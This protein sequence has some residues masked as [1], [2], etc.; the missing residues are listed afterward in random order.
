MLEL[1]E[2]INNYEIDNDDRIMIRDTMKAIS[3]A[4]ENEHPDDVE[5]DIEEVHSS[6]ISVEGNGTA[7]PSV[8][9]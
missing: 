9:V 3:D 6:T 8:N 4:A 5:I 1:G 2:S 7:H